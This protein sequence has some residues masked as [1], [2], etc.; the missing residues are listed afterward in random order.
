MWHVL[1]LVW[2]LSEEPLEGGPLACTTSR[3]GSKGHD[4]AGTENCLQCIRADCGPKPET[5]QMSKGKGQLLGTS[6]GTEDTVT[7]GKMSGSACSSRQPMRH[8]PTISALSPLAGEMRLWD[9]C[10]VW[11]LKLRKHSLYLP[12]GS[13]QTRGSWPPVSTLGTSQ[14][15]HSGPWVSLALGVPTHKGSL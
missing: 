2:Q 14:N 10:V 8:W 1:R 3:K 4:Q 11:D 6:N 13:C 15:I 12:P 5:P 9:S 7:P